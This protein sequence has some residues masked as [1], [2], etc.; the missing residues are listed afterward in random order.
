MNILVE[1]FFI[2]FFQFIIS[3]ILISGLAFTGRY[4]N[5]FLFKD[6]Q[7]ILL[8]IVIGLIIFSQLLKIASI[9]EHKKSAILGILESKFHLYKYDDV[10]TD[11]STMVEEGLFSGKENVRI[12]YLKA[13]SL[14]KTNKINESL[15]EFTW[16][17]ENTEGEL[18]AEAFYY[19]SLLLNNVQKYKSSQD[20]IF[21]LINEMPNYHIWIE[22][23]F[24][25]LAKN[26]IQ[27]EDMFQAQH[28]LLELEKKCQNEDVLY[29]L[30]G[31][32]NTHFPNAL[33]SLNY[34]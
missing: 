18:R 33:D 10:I 31:L 20:M 16:L 22:K 17:I 26:Y 30:R 5:N 34:K 27:Q 21:Q 1:P 25:I 9:I 7:I 23:S 15:I 19:V 13:F 6:Y 14:Y 29:E 12:H 11:I 8:D 24:L 4:I 2:G 3:L 28:V 32:L